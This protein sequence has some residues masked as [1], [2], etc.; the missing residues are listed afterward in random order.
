MIVYEFG[1][2]SISSEILKAC[3]KNKVSRYILRLRIVPIKFTPQ[4]N[5]INIVRLSV[6]I[7]I[8]CDVKFYLVVG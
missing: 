3:V 2:P 7:L 5:V 8:N 1:E 4:Y 6:Y